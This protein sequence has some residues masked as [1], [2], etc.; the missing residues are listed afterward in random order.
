MSWFKSRSDDKKLSAPVEPT[1]DWKNYRAGGGDRAGR[2][3]SEIYAIDD[4]YII[5]FSDHHFSD[6]QACCELFYEV[7]DELDT[8]L[9]KADAALARIN[10]LLDDYQE[11]GSKEYNF[12][13]STLELAADGLEMIFRGEKIEG[14]EI[15]SGLCDKLQAKEEGQR[16]LNYQ[17][18]TL[19]IAGLTWVLY[20]S[21][22]NSKGF[23]PGWEPWILAAALAMAG[24]FFSVCATIGSLTVNVNQQKGFLF[25]A[26]ATRAVVA[27]LAGTGLLLAMRSKMFAGITYNGE[28][29]NGGD[30]LTSAEMFFCFLAGFSESFVPNLLTR[31]ADSKSAAQAKA[32]ADKAAADAKAAAEAKAAAAKAEAEAKAAAE[33]AAREKSAGAGAHQKHE[34]EKPHG[35]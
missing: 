9:G 33:K 32:D 26:G 15:L 16:R 6:T 21:L 7:T 22:N 34:P 25:G 13:Y 12:N 14:L 19:A 29:P 24:G 5:Y 23:H 31:T 3:I 18:G 35:Q 27:L 20:L 17:L 11:K 8:D 30:A 28:P 1:P 10:R 4:D 2:K